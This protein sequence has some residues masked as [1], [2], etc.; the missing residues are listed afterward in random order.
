M[1]L[2]LLASIRIISILHPL[3]FKKCC[4]CKRVVIISLCGS[5]IVFIFSAISHIIHFHY[6]QGK[7]APIFNIFFLII[8]LINFIVPTSLFI[9]LHCFKIRALRRS[10]A[11]NTI[12]AALLTYIT[13]S[14]TVVIR[15]VFVCMSPLYISFYLDAI[16]KIS[17]LIH[18]IA[19]PFIY[20]LTTR[21]WLQVFRK[22]WQFR[23]FKRSANTD[24]THN[25][26]MR[27]SPLIQRHC[28]DECDKNW[29]REHEC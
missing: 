22:V 9:T 23:L 25:I 16:I 8:F 12:S 21:S 29:E 14:V 3:K 11:L 6:D 2:C 7:N 4:S 17:F 19:N 27:A 15:Q 1:Q 24:R 26:E 10:P 20:F 13:S 28:T 18:C 5:A